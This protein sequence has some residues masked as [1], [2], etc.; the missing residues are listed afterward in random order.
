MRFSVVVLVLLATGCAAEH[1]FDVSI[2]NTTG[3]SLTIGLVKFGPPLQAKWASPEDFAIG[4]P[5]RPEARWGGLLP[6]E[7]IADIR[8]TGKFG[9][10][11]AAFVR[12]YSGDHTLSELLAM[13]RRDPGRLD[14]PITP[15][16]NMYVI[17]TVEGKLT[18]DRVRRKPAP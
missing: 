15:G 5:M 7:K 8:Q 2:K 17:S 13:G 9:Q 1:S 4:T 3:N 11:S 14:L 16:E 12:I 10:G 18:A 6:P